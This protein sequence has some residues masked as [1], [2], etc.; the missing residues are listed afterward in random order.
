MAAR[1]APV[2][3]NWAVWPRKRRR[4]SRLLGHEKRRPASCSSRYRLSLPEG[5]RASAGKTSEIIARSEQPSRAATSVRLMPPFLS[6]CITGSF[7][8][9]RTV[10]KVQPVS[11]SAC[12]A[13]AELH[14]GVRPV[15]H[16]CSCAMCRCY[17]DD[18][19][20]AKVGGPV[21]G[22]ERRP[23]GRRRISAPSGQPPVRPDRNAPGTR[24]PRRAPAL[25]T[26]LSSSGLGPASWIGPLSVGP[27]DHEGWNGPDTVSAGDAGALAG[28]GVPKS[29]G[30]LA[31]GL[32]IS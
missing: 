18:V 17:V 12:A 5:I 25:M 6:K 31:Q 15:L 27:I 1:R 29:I 20:M 13:C 26:V 4:G 11:A 2:L 30:E 22:A 10:S 21:S 16:G 32:Q 19:W 23:T 24:R 28:L 9:C 3:M 14:L 8:N 7:G